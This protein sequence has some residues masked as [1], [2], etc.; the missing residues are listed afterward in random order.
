MFHLHD[1]KAGIPRGIQESILCW[2]LWIVL[3]TAFPSSSISVVSFCPPDFSFVERLIFEFW[4]GF[5]AVKKKWWKISIARL[6][7]TAAVFTSYFPLFSLYFQFLLSILFIYSIL[8]QGLVRDFKSLNKLYF[9]PWLLFA[10]VFLL[11][12]NPLHVSL[13]LSPVSF[14]YLTSPVTLSSWLWIESSHFSCESKVKREI[15]GVEWEEA[16]NLIYS[17]PKE[18]KRSMKDSILKKRRENIVKDVN[19]AC[20]GGS[21]ESNRDFLSDCVS[22]STFFFEGNVGCWLHLTCHESWH[23]MLNKVSEQVA[24]HVLLILWMFK[25]INSFTPESSSVSSIFIRSIDPLSKPSITFALIENCLRQQR[26]TT[27]RITSDKLSGCLCMSLHIFIY[28]DIK[29][30]QILESWKAERE[31][32]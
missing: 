25:C 14:F 28:T 3:R 16:S 6:L 22:D 11:Q 23:M 13:I 31:E 18:D 4:S 1:A 21:C 24:E 20:V 19:E 29:C 5:P 8:S 32:D 7:C 15:L 12:L 2:L 9:R 10:A 26:H 17:Q 27:H 30:T